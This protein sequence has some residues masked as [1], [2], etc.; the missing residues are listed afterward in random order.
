[1]RSPPKTREPVD[2]VKPLWVPRR[3]GRRWME[4]APPYVLSC[5]D[6]GDGP[7]A[8]ADRYTVLFWSRDMVV[9]RPGQPDHGRPHVDYLGMSGAPTHPQG[10][11]QWGEL[12]N[13][14]YRP[15]NRVRWLDLPRHIRQHCISRWHSGAD[16]ARELTLADYAAYTGSSEA[17]NTSFPA[18]GP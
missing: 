7:G 8:T 12:S 16:D 9:N 3:A 13:P 11:S 4:Q 1:M 17:E 5:H 15:R 14:S 10:V 6:D 18:V 2:Q